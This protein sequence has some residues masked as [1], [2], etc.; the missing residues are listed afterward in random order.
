[1]SK[2]KKISTALVTVLVAALICP[3]AFRAGLTETLG[4]SSGSSLSS[5]SS[6]LTFYNAK[7]DLTA[8]YVT[9]EVESLDPNDPA[10]EDDE[11]DF[12]LSQTVGGATTAAPGMEY[13]LRDEG[14]RLYVY[15]GVQTHK[16]DK[17]KFEDKLATD[18]HGMFTLKA[19]QTA[20]FDGLDQGD[21]FVIEEV[22]KR[23]YT[24]ISPA[25]GEANVTLLPDGT[26]LTFKNQYSRTKPGTFQ[27]RKNVSYPEGYELP[28]TPE[29]TFAVKIAGK[30]YKNKDY[31]IREIET[32]NEIGTGTTDE[33]GHLTLKGQTYA[34]FTG[35]PEDV[36][37]TVSEILSTEAS[38]DGWRIV[39]PADQSGATLPDQG[40]AVDFT[41]VMAS[42]AVSKQMFGGV[43]ANEAFQFQLL[44]EN[45]APFGESA[46]YYLYDRTL[47]LVDEEIH[48]TAEDGTFTLRDGQKAVFFGIAKGTKFGVRELDQGRYI[49]FIPAA[50]EGYTDKVVKDSVEVIPFVNAAD[51]T[52]TLLTV[53][54]MVGE[55]VADDQEGGASDGDSGESVVPDVDFT[56]QITQLVDG[57][58][59]PVP[60]AAY[61]IQRGSITDTLNADEEGKFTLKAWE[62][63]RFVELDK[64]ET[65]RVQEI[66]IPENFVVIG[67]DTDEGVLTD[68][69]LE[70]KFTNGTGGS[71]D[72]DEHSEVIDVLKT[73]TKDEPLAGA[74]MQLIMVDD[75]GESLV[76]EWVS[77]ETA[78][79]ISVV[80]GDYIIREIV[81]P[82]GYEVAEDI[83]LTVEATD[84]GEE[85]IYKVSMVDKRDSTIPTGVEIFA[86][87]LGRVLLVVLILL[88]AA[89][90]YYR[91]RFM[92]RKTA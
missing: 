72:G 17:S 28:E 51:N 32:D 10:P 61:D 15:D 65:Y 21:T 38:E 12:V 23:N 75:E 79:T 69:V 29:F 6:Y 82:N 73:N 42:F 48:Y 9:K 81:A 35:V 77:A 53:K 74:Q 80:P 62:T 13:Y 36:D 66:E 92:R 52:E 59:V 88:A 64:N 55:G 67:E 34:L 90:I 46:K 26:V 43:V 50:A 68:E 86:S 5:L 60:N 18:D 89:A 63:A 85:N 14:G 84:G 40:T 56:F 78:E 37:Y 45:G 25:G 24:Q 22:S 31:S 33:N 8:L 1:M 91:T 54:K 30:P 20:V 2:K 83:K 16:E 58:Y 87:P 49:Q 47:Q 11:F 57:E 71:D 27:V 39:G 4:F 41:N 44:D 3:F 7:D 19:G 70:T 76:H